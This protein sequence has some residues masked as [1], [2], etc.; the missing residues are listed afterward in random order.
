MTSLKSAYCAL[1][2]IAFLVSAHADEPADPAVTALLEAHNHAREQEGLGPL[3]LSLKL[4]EAA[5]TQAKDMAGHGKLQHAGSDGSAAGDRIKRKGYHYIHVGENI[6]RGQESAQ[7]AMKSWMKSSSHRA[8]ILGEF[9]EFGA[10]YKDDDSGV[11]YWCVNFATP[12]PRLPPDAAAASVVEEINRARQ[13]ARQPRLK[14]DRTLGRSAMALAGAMAARDSLEMGG[15]PFSVINEKD[16][17]GREFRLGI[18]S[19]Q[20]TPAEAIT[21]L[22]AEDKAELPTFR[23]IGAGYAVAKSGTPYWCVFLAKPGKETPPGPGREDAPTGK[24]RS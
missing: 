9:T 3:K 12:M 19:G 22:L 5:A 4:C 15:D 24:K 17:R 8:N 20:P 18:S 14:V 1:I 7:A 13:A 16:A 2:A 21:S 10:A 23:E 11:R 6:A